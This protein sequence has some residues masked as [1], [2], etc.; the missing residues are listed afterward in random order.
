MQ[1]GIIARKTEKGTVPA[2][3]YI[4]GDVDSLDPLATSVVD[5]SMW[6]AQVDGVGH[7][8]EQEHETHVLDRLGSLLNLGES[9]SLVDP[10]GR[11]GAGFLSIPG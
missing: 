5:E 9:N 7:W 8:A 4:N 11:Q 6:G 1:K 3:F 10:P 2:L